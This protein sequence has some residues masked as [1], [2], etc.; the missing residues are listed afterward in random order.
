M[1]VYLNYFIIISFVINFSSFHT[2]TTQSIILFPVDFNLYSFW[3]FQS[4]WYIYVLNC[5]LMDKSGGCKNLVI[6]GGINAYLDLY[7]LNNKLLFSLKCDVAMSKFNKILLIGLYIYSLNHILFNQWWNISVSIHNLDWQYIN[8]LWF[9]IFIFVLIYLHWLI[10]LI[11]LKFLLFYF[12][13]FL[14]L[15]FFIQF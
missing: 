5:L 14:N 8:A 13:M 3:I 7:L 11:I 15:Q 12:Q 10:S 6:H 4:L 1:P 2:Y 9:I